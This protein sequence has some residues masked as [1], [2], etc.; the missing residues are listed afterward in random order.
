MWD[1]QYSDKCYKFGST[2]PIATMNKKRSQAASAVVDKKLWVVGGRD[3]NW[4]HLTSTE[5]VDPAT[6]NVE[7]GPNLPK[8][9]LAPCL[10][11]FNTTAMLIGGYP[12]PEDKTWTYNFMRENKDWVAGPDLNTGR[13]NHA[14]GILKDSFDEGQTI[15]V[16]AGGIINRDSSTNG[17]KSTEILVLGSDQWWAGPDLKYHIDD[18]SGVTTPD[19]KSFLLVGGTNYDKNY[20]LEDTIFKLKCHNL[21]CMWTED[22]KKLQV[23]RDDFLVA[24]LPDSLLGCNFT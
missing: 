24:F 8:K 22:D 7:F 11:S 16:L 3:E 23:G 18:A 12:A 5:F 14:C 13:S 10:V 6:G 9:S 20:K 15:V 2:T 21:E 1:G 19:G 17:L 4:Y